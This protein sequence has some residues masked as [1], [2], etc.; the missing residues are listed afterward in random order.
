LKHPIEAKVQYAL[1]RRLKIELQEV[2]GMEFKEKLTYKGIL[3]NVVVSK[4]VV[5]V[6]ALGRILN[7]N[8]MNISY[9]MQKH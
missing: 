4:I 5:G 6:R 2:K 8:L 7:I 3:L 1:V 9:V